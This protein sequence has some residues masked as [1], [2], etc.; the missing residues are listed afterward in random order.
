MM[1]K[2]EQITKMS[3]KTQRSAL[4]F[5]AKLPIEEK[6]EL[7]EKHKTVFYKFK[8]AYSDI[9]PSVLSYCALAIVASSLKNNKQMLQ[10]ANF[11]NLSIDEILSLS[12]QQIQIFKHSKSRIQQQHEQVIKYW[13]LIKTLK[14]QNISFRDI[15]VY[16]QKY[17]RISIS[18]STIFKIYKKIEGNK[19]G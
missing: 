13:S 7:F 14:S 10:S 12:L 15:S 9:S 8:Q 1:E 2:V 3:Q 5:F 17:H 16:M 4:C 6:L 19:N 18:Y 11:Q